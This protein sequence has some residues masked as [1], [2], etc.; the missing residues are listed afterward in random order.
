[1]S[2]SGTIEWEWIAHWK[3]AL[4]NYYPRYSENDILKGVFTVNVPYNLPAPTI[5]DVGEFYK[6]VNEKTVVFKP[7]EWRGTVYPENVPLSRHNFLTVEQMAFEINTL[8]PHGTIAYIYITS[9]G[10]AGLEMIYDL[11]KILESHVQVVD[12]ETLINLARQRGGK[13]GE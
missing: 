8:Y 13:R 9:D 7:R 2:T 6:I 10:G 3:T 11:V 4:A 5:F 12:H 1:L